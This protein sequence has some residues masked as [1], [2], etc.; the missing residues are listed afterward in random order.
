[1]VIILDIDRQCVTHL[2]CTV[3]MCGAAGVGEIVVGLHDARGVF[4][5]MFEPW[6]DERERA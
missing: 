6:K 1:M 4:T 5:V 2:S 3:E